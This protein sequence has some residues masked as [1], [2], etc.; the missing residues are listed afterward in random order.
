MCGQHNRKRSRLKIDEDRRSFN[1]REIA[2]WSRPA[3]HSTY[4]IE[5]ELHQHSK[6][7][8]RNRNNIKFSEI[9]KKITNFRLQHK[10][11]VLHYT[12]ILQPEISS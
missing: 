7:K 4:N 12:H 2:E 6:A 9:F 3:A 11:P 8:L 1:E 5:A 10:T